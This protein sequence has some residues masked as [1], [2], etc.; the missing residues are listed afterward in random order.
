MLKKAV[1]YFPREYLLEMLYI[2]EPTHVLI[3]FKICWIPLGQSEQWDVAQGVSNWVESAEQWFSTLAT[4]DNHLER[5]RN[6]KREKDRAGTMNPSLSEWK[7]KGGPYIYCVVG[8]STAKSLGWIQ[9]AFFAVI[10]IL[11]LRACGISFS[12]EAIYELFWKNYLKKQDESCWWGL[13]EILSSKSRKK[14]V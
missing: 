11:E 4:R 3:K 2:D 6:Q 14:T 1:H 5:F 7:G 10:Q 13:A 9:G 12:N 8:A